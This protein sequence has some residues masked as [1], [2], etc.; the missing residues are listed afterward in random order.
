MF[1]IKIKQLKILQNFISILQYNLFVYLHIMRLKSI[2]TKIKIFD[3][4]C[5]IKKITNLMVF[6]KF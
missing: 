2:Q 5:R 1:L 6:R 3:S 4:M